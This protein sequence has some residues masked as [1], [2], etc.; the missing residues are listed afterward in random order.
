MIGR[1]TRLLARTC[2]TRMFETE[3][4][5]SSVSASTAMMWSLAAL[6]TPGVMFSGSQYYF[7]AHARTF[8]PDVQDRILFVSQVFHVDFAMAIAAVVSMLVWTSIAPDRRDALV[9][10]PLPVANGEQARARLLA[11]LVFFALFAAAVSIPTAVAFTF[12]TVGDASVTEVFWR[13]V[14]HASATLLGAAFVFFVV[15]TVQLL[16]AAAQG[17]RA[18]AVATWPLQAAAVLA[19]V[20]AISM[21]SRL[22]DALLDASGAANVWVMWN[23]AAWFVG[24]YR[25]IAGDAREIFSALAMR[26]VS[27]TAALVALTVAAYPL[28]YG[29]CVN[30]AIAA[31][32]QRAAWWSGLASRLWLRVMSPLLRTPLERGLAAFIVATLSRSHTHRFLIGSYMGASLLFALPLSGRLLSPATTATEY[33]AWFS[34]PLG[35]ICWAAAAMRVAMM[36]PVEPAS[37]WLFKLT[38]PVDKARV[39]STVATVMNGAVVLPVAVLFACG[40]AL[41][42]DAWLAAMVL[43]VVI[44]TGGTLTETLT[45]TLRTVPG[46]CTYRPGQLRLRLLW[47]V[48]LTIWLTI[49]YAQPAFAV[50]ALRTGVIAVALIASTAAAWAA[51]WLWRI[52][53]GR[54]LVALVYEEAEPRATTTIQLG[55]A[56]V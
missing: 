8:T 38:E 22:A 24:V 48:Y 41:A 47:P 19:M 32:G 42:G 20:A 4:F 26:A 34:V 50:A 23:P 7:Y 3:V 18:I 53:R 51:L 5:S 29:R 55:P 15:V 36:L 13:I 39:L 46:A 1:R 12:V 17:P 37:N 6:A 31:E 25:S 54:R 45:L 11:L 40:A 33:Y 49:A 52:R 2:F 10:G 21:T 14:G 9:L 44:T 27:V 16:L 56:G 35:L 43:A 28:A 30:N